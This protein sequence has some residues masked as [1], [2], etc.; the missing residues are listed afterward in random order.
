MVY[1]CRMR[2]ACH[3]TRVNAAG[4]F[5]TPSDWIL[6][7]SVT[8][9]WN[10]LDLWL[11]LDGDARVDTPDGRYDLAPG[12]C[13]LLRGGERY[14]FQ[15]RPGRVLTHFYVHFDYRRGG[16]RLDHR[17]L[18]LPP[19]HCRIGDLEL[20]APLLERCVAARRAERDDEAGRWLDAALLELD[21]QLEHARRAADEPHLAAIDA[22]RL[23]MREHPERDHPVTAL[24]RRAG[25]SRGRFSQLFAQRVGRP[26]RTYLTEQRMRAAAALLRESGL[27]IGRIAE[28]LG[29]RDA[30][31]FSRHFKAHHGTSPSA[32]REG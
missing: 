3:R 27:P 25:L 32:F 11:L 8:G 17:R 13:L 21:H 19:L 14:D 5:V 28:Q 18:P 29:Y 2:Y 26:P 22:A 16:R 15:R 24:A 1:F 31:F 23:A 30:H 10:D 4:R 12:S 9:R 6:D 7:G 20:L